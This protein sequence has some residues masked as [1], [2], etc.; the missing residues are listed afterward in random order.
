MEVMR[1]KHIALD[2]A[3]LTL[4][5]VALLTWL[6]LVQRPSSSSQTATPVLLRSLE[7]EISRVWPTSLLGE[8]L[9]ADQGEY[10]IDY[11]TRRIDVI[12]MKDGRHTQSIPLYHYGAVRSFSDVGKRF[13]ITGE[14]ID[15]DGYL[16]LAVLLDITGDGKNYVYNIFLFDPNERLLRLAENIGFSG[17][18]VNPTFVTK[19]R[20]ITTD[21]YTSSRWIRTV[22]MY[23]GAQY[24]KK[25]TT[26]RS[27]VSSEKQ[28]V[29]QRYPA[30]VIS[31]DGR[32]PDQWVY[33]VRLITPD[34]RIAT[35][36]AYQDEDRVHPRVVGM[37][38]VDCQIFGE[39]L[40]DHRYVYRESDVTK[41]GTF[42]NTTY[43]TCDVDIDDG[44]RVATEEEIAVLL[45]AK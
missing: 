19:D 26:V 36:N 40:D 39:W 42:V 25:D 9:S 24:V 10:R 35:C 43:S 44:P 31:Q 20:I 5:F 2:I 45:E 32:Y 18:I 21:E 14:D 12:D 16:D 29:P 13:L 33:G 37:C 15:H 4:G 11:D 6:M 3:A 27:A 34:D 30:G 1:R 23:D 22:Y 41:L 38:G 8:R 17:G 28:V 7:D